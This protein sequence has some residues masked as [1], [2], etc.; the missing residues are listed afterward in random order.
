MMFEI[1]KERLELNKADTEKLKLIKADKEK[2]RLNKA[3]FKA[4]AAE[5]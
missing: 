1:N 4:E 3:D 5:N 2:L